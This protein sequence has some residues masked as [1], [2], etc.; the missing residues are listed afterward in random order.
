MQDFF[1][2]L[3]LVLVIEGFLYAAFPEAMKKMLEQVRDLPPQALRNAGLGGL[4]IGV[5][6]VW[7]IRH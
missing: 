7:L 2:G 6:L 4:A 5:G 3:A 1:V